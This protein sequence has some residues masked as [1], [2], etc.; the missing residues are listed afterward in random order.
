[1]HISDIIINRRY[2]TIHTLQDDVYVT[3]NNKQKMKG[4]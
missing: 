4:G 3:K 1:M 2:F